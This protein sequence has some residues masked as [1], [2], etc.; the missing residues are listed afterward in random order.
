MKGMTL[1]RISKACGGK[2]TGGA[3]Q[4]SEREITD[5][6]TD[7]RKVTRGCLF[8]ALSGVRADGRDFIGAAIESGAVCALA[9]KPPDDPG[10]PVILV[11]SACAALRM[12]AEDYRRD[13]DIPVIGVTG[14]VG[15]TTTK[16]M[17]AAALSGRLNVLKTAGNFNNELGVPLTL[18]RLDTDAEA[19][20]VEMGVS[21]FGE[22]SRLTRMSRP[23]IAVFTNIGDAHMEQF[24]NR[25]GTLRA[26]SEIL[27]GMT[28]DGVVIVNGDDVLLRGMT[29]TQRKL[30]YGG[31][32]PL[33][34]RAHAGGGN[35]AEEP[36]TESVGGYD[37]KAANIRDMGFDGL[38]CEVIEKGGGPAVKLRVPPLGVNMVYAALAGYAVGRALGLN[39]E[40][41][42]AGLLN[43]EPSPHRAC[44]IKTGRLT[45][46]D[47]CYNASPASMRAAIDAM[48]VNG[49]RVV[50]L[51]DM[52]ELGETSPELHR[53]AGRYAAKSG[54]ELIIAC[55]ERAAEIYNGA[56]TAGAPD[57]RYY[58]GKPEL[59]AELASIVR[60]GDTA[61]VKASRGLRFED[62][63][64]ALL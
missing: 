43:Y 19:A 61:L 2:L 26:K 58:P 16:D 20:V 35:Q 27:D 36:A 24:G 10:L 38:T 32:S 33:T 12:I 54:A 62:L 5:I 57:A 53:E 52:L 48:P 34:I 30:M 63:V 17:T 13:F 40:D 3:G 64:E 14:S 44:V 51:G 49:R 8:A 47:D 55:G 25:D 60:E 11:E 6:T 21:D 28:R 56:V 7:S 39:G 22:M 50:I 1:Q 31:V 15:K 45:V 29:C 4:L 9:E 59:I 46:I 41:I 37:F 18:F 23:D 42:A